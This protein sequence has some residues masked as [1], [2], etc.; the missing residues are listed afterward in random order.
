[1]YFAFYSTI[2]ISEESNVGKELASGEIFQVSKSSK[3]IL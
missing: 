2:N 3:G 1:M